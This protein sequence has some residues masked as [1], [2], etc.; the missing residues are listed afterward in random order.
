MRFKMKQMVFVV[1]AAFLAVACVPGQQTLAATDIA[2]QIATA[3]AATVSAQQTATAA[4]LPSVTETVTATVTPT[5]TPVLPTAT[6][7]VITPPTT[8]SGGGGGG[9]GGQT[10]TYGCDPDTGKRPRDNSEYRSG[11]S[12]DIKWTIINTGSATWPAG[13]DFGYFSGPM[14]T[15]AGTIELPAMDPGDSYSV[16]FDANAPADKGF[17]VMTWK[18][19]GANCYPYVAIIVK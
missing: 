6:P 7:F 10:V 9:G 12:F 8:S 1:L 2:D 5:E 3:V 14:M 4:A 15:S 11:D 19:Q 16:V 13:T 17:Q 18:V